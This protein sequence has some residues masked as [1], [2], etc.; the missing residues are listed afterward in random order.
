MT[1]FLFPRLCHPPAHAI[2]TI[3]WDVVEEWLPLQDDN[4]NDY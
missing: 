3:S 4:D 1:S 2:L